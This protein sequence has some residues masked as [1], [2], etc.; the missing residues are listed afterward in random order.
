MQEQKK[1]PPVK[2]LK[3]YRANPKKFKK[4]KIYYKKKL[5]KRKALKRLLRSFKYTRDFRDF[6]KFQKLRLTNKISIRIRSNNVFCSFIK[7]GKTLS[8]GSAGI[9]K[10][11]TSI[12]K[13]RFSSKTILELFFRKIKRHLNANKILINLVGPIRIKKSIIKLLFKLRRTYLKKYATN[14]VV[15]TKAKKC[16][17]GCRPKKKVRKKRRYMRVT[18]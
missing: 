9:Y 15:N 1:L 14:L 6:L 11:K 5:K 18:K 17:N 12:K 16:F 8:V 2:K 10:V 3:K 4:T 7:S 13:L